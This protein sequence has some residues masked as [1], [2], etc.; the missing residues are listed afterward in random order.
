VFCKKHKRCVERDGN[1]NGGTGTVRKMKVFVSCIELEIDR[2][3]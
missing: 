2:K 3:A 1:S